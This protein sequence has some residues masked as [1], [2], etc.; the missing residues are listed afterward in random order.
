[1]LEPWWLEWVFNNLGHLD[2]TLLQAVSAT[3]LARCVSNERCLSMGIR[4][5][6]G[7]RR[8]D[9]AVNKLLKSGSCLV[10]RGLNLFLRRPLH[11]TVIIIEVFAM[12]Q[13]DE[14]FE[15]RL[16]NLVAALPLVSNRVV[17]DVA[18]GVDLQGKCVPR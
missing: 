11:C 9:F 3:L 14:V 4:D 10:C 16:D 18:F 17:A 1:M 12:R 15:L 2:N 5:V 7:L 13:G 8:L 6:F